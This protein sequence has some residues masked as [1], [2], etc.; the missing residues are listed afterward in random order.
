MSASIYS[1]NNGTEV[2]HQ[3]G[4]SRAIQSK[5]GWRC[6]IKKD[7]VWFAR[8]NRW[9]GIVQKVKSALAE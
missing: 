1:M 4:N 2:A 5:G 7:G 8:S 6:E 3:F 9:I